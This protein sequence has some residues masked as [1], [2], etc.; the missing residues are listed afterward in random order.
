MSDVP[1][2]WV[3]G[4]NSAA[5]LSGPAADVLLVLMHRYGPDRTGLTWSGDEAVG[6]SVLSLA[7]AP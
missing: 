3:F 1:G 5:T 7:L 2:E 4:E 6:R